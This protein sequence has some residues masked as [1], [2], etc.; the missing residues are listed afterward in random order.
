MEKLDTLLEC[1]IF[2][3]LSKG[4]VFQILNTIH[5]QSRKF[6]KG[7]MIAMA[8]E[9]TQHLMILVK[10]E[11]KG[12]MVDFSG[13]TIKI[14]NISPPRT[15]AQ[16]F[17]F[18]TDNKLPVNVVA[19]KDS[20]I[21]FITKTALLDMFSKNQKIM[22]NYLLVISDRAAFLSEKIKFLSFKTLKQKIVYYV[23]N[24]AGERFNYIEIPGG[25]KELAELF[26]VTR[27]S[28]GRALNDL[29]EKGVIDIQNKL[30]KLKNR[31]MTKEII[32]DE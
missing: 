7:E 6:R 9:E 18:A 13:K 25:Q 22:Q 11:I 29:K 23:L 32:Q 19:I 17:L 28:L 24:K 16:A 3:G 21:L 12:E 14:E 15:I 2:N 1:K 31:Q 27:P 5:Y 4:E 20:E 26:G 8:G 30:I 10:G